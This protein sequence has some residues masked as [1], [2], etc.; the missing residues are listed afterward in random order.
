M[1][2]VRVIA[3][4][5]LAVALVAAPS[6]RADDPKAV[7]ALNVPSKVIQ[8]KSKSWK[9]V[10]DAY[11]AMT[12]PPAK[13]GPD[14]NP[15]AV[16]PGMADWSKVKE[17]AAANSGMAKALVAAYDKSVAEENLAAAKKLPPDCPRP[18]AGEAE[19]IGVSAK[20]SG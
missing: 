15:L 7:D 11:V 3:I 14:F 19:F 20:A 5:A 16:W 13:Q 6:A 9:A 8:D 10:F 1:R 18:K 12:P 4:A 17:W 2:P